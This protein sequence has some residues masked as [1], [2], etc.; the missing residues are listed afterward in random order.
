M[1][2]IY[3]LDRT[4]ARMYTKGAW[5]KLLPLCSHFLDYEGIKRIINEDFKKELE[6][7]AVEYSNNSYRTLLLAY[8]DMPNNHSDKYEDSPDEKLVSNLTVITLVGI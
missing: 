4:V 7:H 1:S 8:K 6:R 3:E 5:E 2:V